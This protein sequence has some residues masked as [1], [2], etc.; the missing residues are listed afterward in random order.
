MGE[1]GGMEGE[2][3]F[4]IEI[5]IFEVEWFGI[6]DSNR[7]FNAPWARIYLL[8]FLDPLVL[9][10]GPSLPLQHVADLAETVGVFP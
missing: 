10:L 7:V 2:C 3:V 8:V 5:R 1:R 9:L 4:L 6:W